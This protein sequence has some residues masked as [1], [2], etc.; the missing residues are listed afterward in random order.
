MKRNFYLD[1]SLLA[2]VKQKLDEDEEKARCA[3]LHLEDRRT[4]TYYESWDKSDLWLRMVED[5]R[6][7][8]DFIA[9]TRRRLDD[10]EGVYYEVRLQS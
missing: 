1:A 8:L 5:A 6:G 3:L 7:M 10:L 2:W 4:I 9:D